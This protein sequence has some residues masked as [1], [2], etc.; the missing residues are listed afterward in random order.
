MRLLSALVISLCLANTAFAQSEQP[1]PSS[2]LKIFTVDARAEQ[3]TEVKDPLEKLNRKIFTFN[4]T[5]DKH[6]A[7]P[8]AIQYQEKIPEDVRSSY[9]LFRKNL[10]EPMNMV[11]QLIQGKPKRA[12]K[13]LGRFSVNTLT[14]LGFA[15]PAS[16]IGLTAEEESVGTTL[17]YYGINSGAFV[18]LPVLGPSTIRDSLGLAVDSQLSSTSYLLKDRNTEKW[19]LLGLKGLDKRANLLDLERT[20]PADRYSA[21]RDMYLQTTAFEIAEKQGKSMENAFIDDVDVDNFPEDDVMVDENVNESIEQNIDEN[22]DTP[23]NNQ[24]IPE[25]QIIE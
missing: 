20:L 14:S 7:K 21:I 18:M 12:A 11:H 19:S 22:I 15:D 3:A 5:L 17:G 8:I 10:G 16:R 4:E 25:Q 24:D 2:G 6:I 13:T 23:L 1:T 9:R